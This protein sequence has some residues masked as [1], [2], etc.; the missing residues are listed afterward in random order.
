MASEILVDK[1][2]PQSGTALEI[3]SS[4]D[5]ITIPSGA[6]IT[7]SGTASGFG[8][9]LQVQTSS[10]S[11]LGQVSVSGS[12]WT[13]LTTMTVSLTPAATTSTL[14]VLGNSHYDSGGSTNQLGLNIYMD[15][16]GA[17]YNAVNTYI[18]STPYTTKD[19]QRTGFW[20]YQIVASP[21]T[22]S[23]CNFRLYGYSDGTGYID[24][25]SATL[26]VMEIGA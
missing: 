15:I 21:S 8:K 22:T 17:G 12:S 23:A 5:T 14:L 2:D 6:T 10:I 25:K 18:T 13:A 4:G 19:S 3:G 26:T 7:N 1:I 24:M 16:N 11:D 20:S 9:L